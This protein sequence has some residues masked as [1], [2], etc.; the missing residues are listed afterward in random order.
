MENVNHVINCKRLNNFE[1]TF[2]CMGTIDPGYNVSEKFPDIFPD[3]TDHQE[4]LAVPPFHYS[5]YKP[6]KHFGNS[7]AA[8]IWNGTLDNVCNA[9]FIASFRKNLKTCLFAEAYPP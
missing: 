4:Y 8:K 9:I 1:K 6:V 3:G 2:D 5:L 7:F